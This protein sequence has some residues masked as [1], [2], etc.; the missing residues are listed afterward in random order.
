VR[1]ERKNQGA[2]YYTGDVAPS[3]LTEARATGIGALVMPFVAAN[4][5]PDTARPATDCRGCGDRKL[6]ERV[7][8]HVYA[9]SLL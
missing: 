1:V 8:E 4:D 7:V 2:L 9:H 6:T 5:D 3:M